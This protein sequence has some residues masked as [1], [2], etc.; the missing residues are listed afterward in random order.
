MYF[1]LLK[2]TAEILLR[3]EYHLK[4]EKKCSDAKSKSF[5]LN[6]TFQTEYMTFNKP[7][8]KSYWDLVTNKSLLMQAISEIEL[9]I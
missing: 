2:L 3:V 8:R 6:K 9:D 1:R 4:F 5:I 7:V